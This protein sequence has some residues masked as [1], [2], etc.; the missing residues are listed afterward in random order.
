[1]TMSVLSD[2]G[3]QYRAFLEDI[4][5]RFAE[6]EAV[7]APDGRWTYSQLLSEADRFS[8]WLSANGSGPLMLHVENNALGVA[9]VLGS[10][11]GGHCPA[12]VDPTWSSDDIVEMA[13]VLKIENLVSPLAGDEGESVVDARFGCLALR[14]IVDSVK[15]RPKWIGRADFVRFTSG[16]TGKPVALSFS[17][18]AAVAAAKA[19]ARAAEYTM[20]DR[21]L[22]LAHLSNG[23]AFNI[24][25]LA[26][27]CSGATLIPYGGP[28]LKG[29][30]YRAMREE[31]ATV[32]VSFPLAYEFLIKSPQ[33]SVLEQLRL[34]ISS[35]AP[36]SAVIA[37]LWLRHTGKPVC[38]YYGLAEVGP[39][40]FN[41]G[42]EPESVG[43]PLP[44]VDMV[45]ADADG[46]RLQTGALGR[47]HVKTPAMASEYIGC[48]LDMVDKMDGDGFYMTSDCGYF[49]ESG[50]LVL[51]GR[52]DRVMNIEGR[53]IDPAEVEQAIR[54]LDGVEDVS[55]FSHNNGQRTVVVACVESEI[56]DAALIRRLLVDILPQ[57]QRPQMVRMMQQLPRSVSGKIKIGDLR[58]ILKKENQAPLLDMGTTSE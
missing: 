20:K 9:A 23:L 16:S 29:P 40:T 2:T 35:T 14:R 13:R 7:I 53:K 26:V 56:Q 58:M 42:A 6:R 1:M 15:D 43:R 44:G 27:L 5:A 52:A 45:V 34:A 46:T 22:C 11:A 3:T 37:D 38:D 4:C 49:T 39:C 25:L 48:A 30:I 51:A 36:M 32:F 28:L 54:Q 21:V 19:W 55:V 17:A 24:S 31:G 12:I 47:V 8:Y 41:D 33:S 50:N 57:H 18:S 10:I